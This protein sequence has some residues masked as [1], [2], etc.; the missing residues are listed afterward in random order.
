MARTIPVAGA[1]FLGDDPSVLQV[2]KVTIGDSNQDVNVN[3]GDTTVALGQALCSLPYGISVYDVGWRVITA[4]NGG[5]DITLGVDC[6]SDCDWFAT[7]AL[8]SCTTANA[9]LRTTKSQMMSGCSDSKAVGASYTMKPGFE[10]FT[11]DSDGNNL[12][13]HVWQGDTVNDSGVLEVYIY[14]S[15][16]VSS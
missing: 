12:M 9:L 8:I 6:G 15:G 14:Y 1:A 5:V 4:F 7:D 2:L 10:G 16:A 11:P 3:D 13:A